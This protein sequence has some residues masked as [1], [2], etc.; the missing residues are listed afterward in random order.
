VTF[1]DVLGEIRLIVCVFIISVMFSESHAER[2]TSLTNILFVARQAYQLINSIL[3]KFFR[4]LAFL[5]V[6]EF[7]QVI[8]CGL[9]HFQ[10][11][12]FKSF[13][14]YQTSLPIYVNLTHFLVFLFV[15]LS[16]FRVSA[17]SIQERCVVFVVM[18]NLLHGVSFFL[19]S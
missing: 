12:V 18:N 2:S 19:F 17:D 6:Q 5:H 4:F 8:V 7:F 1:Y 14:M 16:L 3:V 10:R 13:V 9:C 11:C 15:S